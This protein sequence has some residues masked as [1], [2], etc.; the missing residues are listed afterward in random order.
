VEDADDSSGHVIAGTRV[1]GTVVSSPTKEKMNTSRKKSSRRTDS[2]SPNGPSYTDSDSTAIPS[3]REYKFVRHST[4]EK[5]REMKIREREERDRERERASTKKVVVRPAMK[6]AKTAPVVHTTSS[7]YKKMKDDPSFYGVQDTIVPSRPRAVTASNPRVPSYYGQVPR[8]P[9]SNA[10]FYAS[11]Q[12]PTAPFPPTS[13]P[14]QTW[15]SAGHVSY[16]TAPTTLH[17]P[18]DYYHAPSPAVGL[19]QAD[20]RSRFQRPTSAMAFRT[21]S[22]T[23][24]DPHYDDYEQENEAPLSRRHSLT[25]KQEDRLRMPP[26]ARPQSAAPRGIG[27]RPPP[28]PPMRPLPFGY[29]DEALYGDRNLY[30][31][32]SPR[33]SVDYSPLTRTRRGSVTYQTPA[34]LMQPAS[35]SSNRRHSYYGGGSS[36][37]DKMKEATAY[38][39]DITGSHVPLTAESLRK[40]GRRSAGGSSRSTRS[41]GS[42][43][44]SDY[45]HSNTTR[46]TRSSGD[47][48]ITIKVTGHTVLKVGGAEIECQ[49]GQINIARQN[50]RSGGSENASTIYIDDGRSRVERL[51]TRIRSSSQSGS[52]S[53]SQPPYDAYMRPKFL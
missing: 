52:Y 7:A 10:N 51:P 48:D 5:E 29:E 6:A 26:P 23:Y 19:A 9:Q 11:H 34:Y 45:R 20:L 30:H 4:K 43:E 31:D 42:R 41:S 12:Q 33:T 46:T 24:A 49:D 3:R 39:D 50:S 18:S 8:P 25:R 36:Y 15:A 1:D 35:A 2:S 27:M 13:Y 14:P 44:D 38:Q 37:E 17:H 28:P 16:P 47:E 22:S 53:R 21:P 40:A 32:V